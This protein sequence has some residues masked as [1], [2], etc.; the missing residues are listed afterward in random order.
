[1]QIAQAKQMEKKRTM[2]VAVKKKNIITMT[3][4]QKDCV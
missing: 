4:K 2:S 1:M 3:K